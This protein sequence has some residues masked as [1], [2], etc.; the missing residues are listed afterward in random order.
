MRLIAKEFISTRVTAMNPGDW[1]KDS[2]GWLNYP[3]D[4]TVK[5]LTGTGAG[6]TNPPDE[7][8]SHRQ[9]EMGIER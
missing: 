2:S 7:F 1:R 4:P 8:A 3:P 5:Q 6:F 9:C